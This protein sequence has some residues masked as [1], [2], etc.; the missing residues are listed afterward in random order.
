MNKLFIKVDVNGVT[1]PFEVDTGSPVILIGE[2]VYQQFFAD[3]QLQ[4]AEQLVGA[5]GE[6]VP[7]RGSFVATLTKGQRDGKVQIIVQAQRRECGLLGVIG[8]DVLFPDWR[9]AFSK[10]SNIISCLQ[11]E[12]DP[13]LLREFGK[14]VK[15]VF[16]TLVDGDFSKP[17]DGVVIGLQLVDDA[18]PIFSRAR[19]VPFSVRDQLTEHIEGLVQGGILKPVQTSDWASPIVVVRKREGGIRMCIDPKRTLNPQLTSDHYPIPVIDDLLVDVSS[20]EYYSLI[21][22]SG[23]FQQLLLDESSQK[24]VTI[25]THLGLFSFTRL[26]FGVKTAPASFQR[27]I[28]QI[29]KRFKFAFPYIDDIIVVASSLQEMWKRVW[30]ILSALAALNVKINLEKCM[31]FRREVRFLGHVIN[32]DGIYPSKDKVDAILNAPPPRD[33][34]EL[35]SFVGLVTYLHKFIPTLSEKLG[36]IFDLEK[37]DQ[38]FVWGKAQQE[39]F[40]QVKEAV[41]SSRFLVHFDQRKTVCVC[42]DAS[43]LGIAAVLCHEING[44]LRPVMFKSRKLSDCEKRYPILHRE[45]LAVVF[46]TEKFFHYVYGRKVK[47]FTDHKPLLGI[48]KA[49]LTLGVVHSRVHRYLFRLNPFDLVPIHKPGKFNVLAD[50]PSRFPIESEMSPEDQLEESLASQ[51]NALEDKQTLN[52]KLLCKESL[53]DPV[54]VLLRRS[55][56]CGFP[57]RLDNGLEGYSPIKDELVIN[58]DLITYQGRVLVPSVLREEAMQMLHEHHFGIVKCKRMARRYFFWPGMNG[59]IEECVSGCAVCKSINPD[60]QPKVFKPWPT[61]TRGL[62]ECMWIFSSTL[63]EHFSSW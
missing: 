32:K 60:R 42:T 36:P 33:V 49:G 59:D 12:Y 51:V 5:S 27:A 17:N 52:F 18:S 6:A 30:L 44:Q 20:H 8:L 15:T 43:N 9:Q 21:D 3:K 56:E 2:Q 31:F 45:L 14:Q 10:V 40:E 48:I 1:L 63:T 41:V 16:P 28:E 29:L 50:F 34:K 54:H 13:S 4:E 11:P 37:K 46:S 61:P 55:I 53:R 22:L 47:L 26:P 57:K 58:G 7:V 24:L 23:A 35:Q 19:K 39:A 62:T 38:L 25:N